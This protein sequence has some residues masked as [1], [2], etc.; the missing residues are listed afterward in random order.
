MQPWNDDLR[1]NIRIFGHSLRPEEVDSTVGSAWNLPTYDLMK[2]RF[3]TFLFLPLMAS[4]LSV[5]SELKAFQDLDVFELEYASDPRISPD[6]EFIVYVRRGMDIMTNKA[7]GRLWILNRNGT[8][9][10]KLTSREVNESSPR[11]SPSG[12]RIAFISS[13]DHG[14]EIH[15]LWTDTF[16]L[17]KITE[18][19]G[20]PS[21]LSWSPD[22]KQIAFSRKITGKEDELVKPPKKP[23][24]AK[25]AEAPRVTTLL[26][27]E[28]DGS[29]H[30]TPGFS[31][32][33]IV[34]AEGAT[35]RQVTSGD[36]HHRGIP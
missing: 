27:H 2:L 20:S 36:F 34:P 16:Q 15:V 13:S 25:W 18:L 11:W 12:D 32:Y 28:R 35:P 30:I 33:F 14:S 9:H 24:G 26:K 23:K 6:G 3:F 4:P 1:I 22:G 17:A 5:A 8:Q 19:D 10:R 31:H 21:G 7:Y 29:G